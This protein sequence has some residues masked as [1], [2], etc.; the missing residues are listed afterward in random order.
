MRVFMLLGLLGPLAVGLCGAA[1]AKDGH[2]LLIGTVWQGKLTQR[3]GGPD[4]FDCGF[5]VTKRDGEKFEAELHA[6]TANLE[7]TY[8]VRGTVKPVAGKEKAK[9]YAVEFV[10]FDVKNVKNTGAV[11]GVPYT[12]TQ[13][14]KTLAGTWT[15]E[16]FNIEGDFEFELGKKE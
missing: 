13:T 3:G 10:S 2:P 6:K 12:A 14:G 9:R 7:L 5:T 11:L 16:E 15:S 1:P 4:T 8:L